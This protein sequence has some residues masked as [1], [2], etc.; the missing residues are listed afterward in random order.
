MNKMDNEYQY[1]KDPNLNELLTKAIKDCGYIDDFIVEVRY[2]Y[3]H[4]TEWNVENEILEYD[5]NNNEFVWLNDWYEGQEDVEY[6]GIIALSDVEMKIRNQ[7]ESKPDES[8]H[9]YHLESSSISYIQENATTYDMI[10]WI[11]D[12]IKESYIQNM[13]M[14][15]Q[16]EANFNDT[17]YPFCIMIEPTTNYDEVDIQIGYGSLPFES[18]PKDIDTF[19]PTI[20]DNHKFKFVDDITC[21]MDEISSVIYDY[22]KS[23]YWNKKCIRG[24]LNFVWRR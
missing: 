4:E 16:S 5:G 15:I 19:P 3:N 13:T 18:I 11:S 22:I 12:K 21:G 7:V 6:T 10:K 9:K 2:K 8:S 20:F 17:N 1:S 14:I 23:T 24:D